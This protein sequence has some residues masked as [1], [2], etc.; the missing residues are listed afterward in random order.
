MSEK[1]IYVTEEQLKELLEREVCL[2]MAQIGF[3]REGY[4][5]V[6]HA[7][8]STD[9]SDVWKNYW[10]EHHDSHHFPSEPHVCPSCLIERDDF[11]GGHV[12]YEGE[13]YIVPVCKNC[14]S[15]YKGQKA[16]EH[17]F[18]VK[19]SDMVPAPEIE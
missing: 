2:A 4:S 15:E 3:P 10:E 9:D 17:S 16:G 8:N 14:N 5:I 11:V 7:V 12:V 1:K 18:Y 13:L 19:T 6:K